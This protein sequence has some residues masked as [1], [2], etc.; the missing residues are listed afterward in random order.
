LKKSKWLVACFIIAGSMMFTTAAYAQTRGQLTGDN[1]RVRETPTLETDYNILFQV[2]RGQT[3]EVLDVSGDFYRVNVRDSRDVYIFR[4]FIGITETVG[5]PGQ[6]GAPLVTAPDADDILTVSDSELSVTGRYG[7]WYEVR[8]NGERAFVESHHLS[9]RLG[10][11]LQ[12]VRPPR[13]ARTSSAGGASKIDD[14]IAYAKGY[15]GVPYRFGSTD[16]SRGFDCSGFVTV[17]MREFGIY[18]QRSSA[19]MASANGFQVNR[20]ELEAGDLV[21]FATG[22][23]GRVSHVGIYIGSDQF[24][25]SAS[26][27]GVKISGMNETYY[28]TRFVRANRVL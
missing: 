4:E 23:G 24:I 20:N 8:Y 14:I 17:V 12:T 16:P 9:V 18:L 19:S 11:S 21:F 7:N 3:V 10:D 2:S 5:A 27:R 25:H 15:I 6:H 26:C 28:R 22:G 1:V 13:A